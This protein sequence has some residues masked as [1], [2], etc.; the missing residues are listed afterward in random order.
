MD[1]TSNFQTIYQSNLYKLKDWCKEKDV[2]PVKAVALKGVSKTG[3]SDDTVK[4]HLTNIGDV[5]VVAHKNQD[6]EHFLVLCAFKADVS[7][8][9]L[10]KVVTVSDEISWQIMKVTTTGSST[11]TAKDTTKDTEVDFMELLQEFCTAHGEADLLKKL[12]DDTPTEAPP[13]VEKVIKY[14]VETPNKPTYRRIRPFSGKTPVPNG[15]WEYETWERVVQQSIISNTSIS[16]QEKWIRITDSLM[17]PALDMAL[18][19][20][21]I[22]ADDIL[23]AL[24]KAYGVVS[25]GDDLYTKFRDTYQESKEKPSEFLVRLNGLLCKV[26]QKGGI[27]ATRANRVRLDQFIRGC[28]YQESIITDLQLSQK[29]SSP[30]SYAD[31]LQLVREEEARK[32]EKDR[33]RREVKKELVRASNAQQTAD[34]SRQKKLEEEVAILKQQLATQNFQPRPDNPSPNPRSSSFHPARR[35]KPRSVFCYKCGG[36]GHMMRECTNNANATLVHQRLMK[37][38]SGNE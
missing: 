17:P 33:R 1:T 38:Q 3:Y 24:Q 19:G 8:L 15:E 27:E 34:T 30:P 23:S 11:E 25:D 18:D 26:V 35:G 31:L 7:T 29:K 28:L 9:T 10:P 5:R 12:K 21:V 16:G 32:E 37:K 2:N 13:A 14:V 4:N 6:E 36:D 22:S 20:D